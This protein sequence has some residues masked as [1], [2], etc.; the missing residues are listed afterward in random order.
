MRAVA[1]PAGARRP[2]R[3]RS[4]E[5]RRAVLDAMSDLL[6]EQTIA[7]VTVEAVAAR[8]R[9]SKATIY[10]WWPSKEAIAIDAIA[11]VATPRLAFPDT[12]STREDL[13]AQLCTS[14]QALVSQMGR[15]YAAL[16]GAGQDDPAL[17]A[18]IRERLISERR[19]QASAALGRG[20]DRGELRGDLDVDTA[21]D[22]IYG[23]LYYRRLISHAPLDA[24]YVDTLLDRLWPALA[25]A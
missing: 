19:A 8:A 17:A 9:V 7:R 12:G 14:V 20:V 6:Q 4:E 16:I 21:I 23:A 24:A 13:R 1:R 3:P 18:A 5:A 22:A 10:R 2:G 15:T 11:A 25:R